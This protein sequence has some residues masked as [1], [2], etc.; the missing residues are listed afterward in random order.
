MNVFKALF[1]NLFWK[2]FDITFMKNEKKN[3]QNINCF[4]SF[5]I[6]IF[7]NYIV[8]QYLKRISEH[9]PSKFNHFHTMGQWFEGFP[10]SMGRLSINA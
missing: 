2:S 10:R 7:F 4:F 1:N 6:K 5:L 8:N 9:K 3:Y